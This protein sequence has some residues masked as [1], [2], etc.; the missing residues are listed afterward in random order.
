MNHCHILQY[1][2]LFFINEPR[3]SFKKMRIPTQTIN[4]LFIISNLTGSFETRSLQ[5]IIK[6]SVLQRLRTPELSLYSKYS[7]SCSFSLH[8]IQT[9]LLRRADSLQ[10]KISFCR[11]CPQGHYRLCVSLS[12]SIH[13]SICLVTVHFVSASICLSVYLSICLFFCPSIRLSVY[14]SVCLSTHLLVRPSV[15]F[16]TLT[17]VCLSIRL[18]GCPSICPSVCQLFLSTF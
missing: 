3:S 6:Y 18:F 4:S 15:C 12:L 14:P 13:P 9:S 11:G 7:F 5:R 16:S 17:Y 1:K 2:A 10:P 8:V